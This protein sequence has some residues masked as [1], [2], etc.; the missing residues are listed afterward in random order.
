MLNKDDNAEALKSEYNNYFTQI[1]DKCFEEFTESLNASND[2]TIER[3]KSILRDAENSL[4][5]LFNALRCTITQGFT[6]EPT[7]SMEGLEDRL[8]IQNAIC[9]GGYKGMV[10]STSP[11]IYDEEIWSL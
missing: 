7:I 2:K 6:L 8:Q 9:H 10:S 4:N 3:Y 11:I 1:I 5:Q